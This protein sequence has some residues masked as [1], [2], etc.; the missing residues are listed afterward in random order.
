MNF[1][2]TYKSIS[3]F[4]FGLVL[5]SA[6]ILGSVHISYSSANS[7]MSSAEIFKPVAE[8][9][10][11]QGV[12]S[13]FIYNLINDKNVKFDEGFVKINVIGSGKAA[14]YSSHYNTRAV[15]KSKTFLEENL[16]I[17]QAAE[18]KYGVPKEVITSIL[19]VETR[20]GG[21]LGNNNIVSVFLSTALADQS[22]FI[23]MNSRTLKET[24]NNDSEELDKYLTKLKDRA[25]YKTKWAMEQLVALEQLN[26]LSP[27]PITEI[28]GSWA[29]AF[30]MSQFLPSS[31]VSWAVDGNNDKV[32]NLFDKEDAIY[33]V[34]NYLN[35]NGWG[36]TDTKK[37]KAVWHY[38]HSN[39]YV[40]AVLKLSELI[41]S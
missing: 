34:G 14:D 27:V 22:I 8:K 10:V 28:N 20:H 3:G 40:D 11:K 19:Y 9:L 6:F 36:K 23:D 4:K 30:G 2:L 26:K 15:S 24:Y 13:A 25:K 1:N 39:A 21:Y 32:V 31:Y 12:D 33:S 18:D 5:C 7:E 16:A 17:L 35:S 37:R 29:G 41:A 38:N